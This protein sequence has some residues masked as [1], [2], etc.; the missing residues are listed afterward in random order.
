M[1]VQEFVKHHVATIQ[2]VEINPLIVTPHRAVVADA[3]ITKGKKHD[4]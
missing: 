3:L 1:K 4:S 2:E